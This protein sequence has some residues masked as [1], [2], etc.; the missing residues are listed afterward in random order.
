MQR[1]SVPQYKSHDLLAKIL[2]KHYMILKHIIIIVG[3]I[4]LSI[5]HYNIMLHSMIFVENAHNMQRFSVPQYKSHDF[6]S[7]K[8]IKTLNNTQTHHTHNWVYN[9]VYIAVFIMMHSIFFGENGHYMQRFSVPQYK[10][11]DFFSK[12]VIKTLY[13]TQTHHTHSWV[14][15]TVYIAI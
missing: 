12:K 10:S 5:Q 14:Y 3:V 2:S 15:N 7:K 9:T 4:L 6:F 8:V 11:H 13:N 1:F